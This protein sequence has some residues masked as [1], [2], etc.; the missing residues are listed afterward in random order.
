LNDELSIDDNEGLDN[1]ELDEEYDLNCAI[2]LK[3]EDDF[4][5]DESE[6]MTEDEKDDEYMEEG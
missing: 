2:E 1:T 6:M 3:S 5:E 4:I